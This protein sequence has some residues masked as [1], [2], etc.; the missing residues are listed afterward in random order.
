MRCILLQ[1]KGKKVIISQIVSAKLCI[2]VVAVD[3]VKG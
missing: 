2:V 3:S 1:I